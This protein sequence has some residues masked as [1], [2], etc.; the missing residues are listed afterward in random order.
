MWG[1]V[2]EFTRAPVRCWPV[3][4]NRADSFTGMNTCHLFSSQP[5]VPV[6]S[7]DV[8]HAVS[9]GDFAPSRRLLSAGDNTVEVM[10]L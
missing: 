4:G 5:R 8:G 6:K 7:K 1:E 3:I 9:G 10:T 2:F